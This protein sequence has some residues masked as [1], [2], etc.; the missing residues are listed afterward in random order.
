MSDR[1][2]R[3][4]KLPLFLLAR[5]DLTATA[6]VV[7]A[8]ISD[9]IGTNASTWAGVRRLAADVGM[10]PKAVL[11][12]IAALESL[13]LLEVDRRGSGRS[14]HYRV[15]SVPETPALPK[16]QRSR[17]DNTG[18]GESPTQA[19]ANR[20]HNQTDP[21]NQTQSIARDG[22]A[23]GLFPDASNPEPAK[24]SPRSRP[25]WSDADLERIYQA[26]P[27]HVGKLKA[28]QAIG[29]ALDRIARSAEAPADPAAWLIARVQK[30]AESPAGQAG[31]YTPHPSTWFNQGRYDDD[32]TQWNRGN[33]PRTAGSGTRTNPARVD[34]PESKYARMRYRSSASSNPPARNPTGT[35]GA[36]PRAGSD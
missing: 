23:D 29:K 24:L 3:F 32:P 4:V 17:H 34:A 28:Q 12:A 19:L 36:D 21:Y 15:K 2:D 27:R 1:S 8:V 33:D 31:E 35:A 16:R 11:R 10:D 5:S 13:G 30:F 26:Y 7:Y 22:L 14:S 18:V 20:P 9:R 25:R 6:K